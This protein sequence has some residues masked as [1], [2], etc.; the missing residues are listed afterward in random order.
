MSRPKVCPVGGCVEPVKKGHLM[1]LAHW[2]KVPR[3]VQRAVWSSF[4]DRDWE[5]WKKVSDQAIIAAE[6]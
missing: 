6:R 3:E 5:R 4:N 2:R 1:C